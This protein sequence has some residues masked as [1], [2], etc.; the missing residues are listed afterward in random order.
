MA[1][2]SIFTH[3]QQLTVWTA[4]M[5]G[6]KY[7]FDAAIGAMEAPDECSSRRYRYWFK[8]LNRFAANIQRATVTK[9]G[10]GN[11]TPG[12]DTTSAPIAPTSTLGITGIGGTNATSNDSK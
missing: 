6:V 10:K 1:G 4:A 3:W 11:G 12:E 8:F 7:A 2:D 5:Q 9:D